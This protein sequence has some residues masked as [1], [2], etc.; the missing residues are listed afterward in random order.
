MVSLQHIVA[1]KAVVKGIWKGFL[2]RLPIAILLFVTAAV[3]VRVLEAQSI[4]H[5]PSDS[6]Y[7]LVPGSRSPWFFVFIG[8]YV[9]S[10]LVSG[11]PE[12]ERESSPWYIWAYRSFHILSA[13]GTSF[14]QNK[15]YWPDHNRVP[16]VSED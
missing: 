15:M 13:S 14:F 12:P 8:W 2:S 1:V 10:A 11:M 7:D 3:T 9:F 16:K 5:Q 6:I 4:L